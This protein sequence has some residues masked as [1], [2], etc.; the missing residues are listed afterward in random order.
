LDL[1]AAVPRGIG[2]R[3]VELSETV[4]RMEASVP[5]LTMALEAAVE[6]CISFTGGVEAEALLRTLDEVVLH[7]LGSLLEVLKSLRSIC[8][9][10]RA[11]PD[12]V[13][14]G[15]LSNL[16]K[17]VALL[18]GAGKKEGGTANLTVDI[19][20]EEEE[21]SIVQGAL[22]LLTVAD[23]L[24]SRSSV[25]EASLRA[26]LTRLESRLQLQGVLATTGQPV[27][28]PIALSESEDSTGAPGGTPGMLDITILRLVN[29]LD[30]TRRLGGLLEQ[31]KDPRFHA[32][33]HT[34]QRVSAFTEAVNELVYEVLI[35]K[36][37]SKLM[38][39]AQMPAW[40]QQEEE[41]LFE[42]PNFSAYPLPYIVSVGEYL[43]TLPQQMMPWAGGGGSDAGPPADGNDENTD[44]AQYFETEWMF[45]I[46]EG[47]TALYI[48][49]IRGIQVLS[50]RGAQQ[51]SADIEYLCNVL[52][53]LSMTAPLVLST[54]QTCVS[55]PRNKLPELVEHDGG[56]PIDPATH[57]LVC[58]MRQVS[59]E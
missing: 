33:P 28:L 17:D 12:A 42:L 51:L 11:L 25:F 8:G 36:V 13:G 46:A 16:K 40:N 39:V 30:K 43:L 15:D 53:I 4:R 14:G 56:P 47:A 26:T 2:A 31:A 21:W 57:R 59:L 45:K 10:D 27:A 50:E 5:E 22:Q 18:E 44:E 9:V 24:S 1:R 35:S 38:D 55:T 20:P 58:K 54:F 6:R 41:N 19:V 7:Y 29:D 52:S 49:Q 48:D 32:L 23:S 3:G 34:S 37:R